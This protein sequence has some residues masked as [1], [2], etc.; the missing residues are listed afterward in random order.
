MPQCK[1][2]GLVSETLHTLCYKDKINNILKRILRPRWC[3]SV[4]RPMV[5]WAKPWSDGPY[6]LPRMTHSPK[7]PRFEDPNSQPFIRQPFYVNVE[8]LKFLFSFLPIN[9]RQQSREPLIQEYFKSMVLA[10][11]STIWI[12][13]NTR[14]QNWVHWQT[15]PLSICKINHLS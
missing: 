1:A 10:Y 14:V 7:I 6:S 3:P 4:R 2:F 9:L 15:V 8:C 12:L 5:W 11:Q 13:K